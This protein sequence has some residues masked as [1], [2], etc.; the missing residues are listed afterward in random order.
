MVTVH[1][2][3][4]MQIKL[5]KRKHRCH[6]SEKSSGCQVSPPRADA[7]TCLVLPAMTRDSPG[8][9]L[10]TGRAPPS[11][12]PQ[13]S[14]TPSSSLPTSSKAATHVDQAVSMNCLVKARPAEPQAFP[15]L[16]PADYSKDPELISQEPDQGQAQRQALLGKVRDLSNPGLLS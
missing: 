7:Q 10:P 9:A 1:C 12:G 15:T 6:G 14:L 3:E 13:S 11:P 8:E 4:R 16:P 5:N 2:S